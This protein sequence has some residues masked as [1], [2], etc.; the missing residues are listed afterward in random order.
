MS[1]SASEILML[2]S[3]TNVVETLSTIDSAMRNMN[4]NPQ[5]DSMHFD[6]Q[7]LLHEVNQLSDLLSVDV[8]KLEP[9]NSDRTRYSVEIRPLNLMI[10]DEFDMVRIIIRRFP[11]NYGKDSPVKVFLLGE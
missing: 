8:R 4:A 7:L 2:S 1:L 11:V 5:I 9:I 3:S 10:A 6:R